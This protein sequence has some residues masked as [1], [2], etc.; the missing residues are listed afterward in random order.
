[1]KKL[2]KKFTAVLAF[3]LALIVSFAFGGCASADKG[4]ADGDALAPGSGSSGGYD[5]A[6]GAPELGDGAGDSADSGG[7]GAEGGLEGGLTG[8]AG[9]TSPDGSTSSGDTG[10]SGNQQKPIV[11]QLTAAEWRDAYNYDFW[12]GLFESDIPF[13]GQDGK[14]ITKN[15]IFSEYKKATRGLESFDMHEVYVT[16][17]ESPVVGA[18][19]NLYSESNKIYS[20]VTDS[21]GTAY[22][23]GSGDRIEAVSGEYSASAE[24][25]EGVTQISLDSYSA[26]DDEI[27]IMFVVD[28]TG[29]MG[30]E[31]SF[32]C[33]E[34]SGIVT[35]VSSSLSCKIR[36]GL[37]F[38][39]DKGD[40]YVTRSFDFVDVT[41]S[42]GLNTVVKNINA[43]FS[44]GGGDYPE[45]VDTAL[46]E[47]VEAKWHDDSKTKLIFHVLDAPY[48][49]E[50]ENQ[51]VFANAVRGAAE[52]GIRIIPVA[53]SGLDTLGQ[54]IMR[55]AALLTG[56]TYT[57]L[58]DDS[59]IGLS[60]E[61]PAV[62]AFTVEYL[63]DLMVR[64]IKGYY[65]GEFEQPVLWS[66]SESV[67]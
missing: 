11:K 18:S 6:P 21:T 9:A 51:S 29:S 44:S 55:S 12:L 45:A 27:E 28:T 1:M 32:L 62:G 25:A 53:A 37:I 33:D 34:L 48:H 13:K 10:S 14:E 50:Q 41:S 30:D 19:V 5:Y 20:A 15:G 58:T 40:A 39:R 26:Y 63:S 16:S 22:V 56:G 17:G 52:K 42:S 60:H 2:F 46:K 23:F 54:Y 67:V 31:L 57:F 66:Q 36:L 4:Y 65:N 49:D 24:I 35:R 59:G 38:Y 61:L 43:Q 8:E 3:V 64:L 7:H 47:A